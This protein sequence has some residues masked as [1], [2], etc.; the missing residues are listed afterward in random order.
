MN[1]I[2]TNSVKFKSNLLI[3]LFFGIIINGY[4][5][6]TTAENLL[7]KM[8]NEG[9]QNSRAMEM[10]SELT[11]VYGPRLNGSREYFAAANWISNEMKDIGIQN[12]HF[13]KYCPQCRG[14]SITSFNLEMTAP[15]YMHISGYP[16]VYTKSSNGKVSGE[17]VHVESYEDM[18]EVKNQFAGNL[19]GKVILLGKEPSRESLSEPL[20]SRFSEEE[21]TKMEEK[22]TAEVKQTPLP[23][24]IKSWETED[25]GEDEFLRFVEAEGGLA[26]LKTESMHLGI[27][28]PAGTYY[29]NM[30][31][32]KP[33][34]YFAIMPE[35]FGR[36]LRM[37][38]IGMVPLISLNLETEFYDESENSVNIIGQ[39]TGSDPKLKK[40]QIIIGAHFD[41]WH[42]STGATDNGANNV[43]LVE[44]LRILTQA[45][46]TPRRT[47]VIGLWGGEELAYLGSLAYA[48]DHFG[49]L[50]EEPNTE[51]KKVSV[52]LNLDS[53][54][55]AIRGIFLQENEFARPVFSKIFKPIKDLCDGTITI[56]NDL[57]T[58]HET[59][60]HYNIPA[61]QFIQD[62]LAYD[63][64]THHTN[65]DVLEYVPEKDIM[66]NAVI[67]A[68]IIY[69][70][71]EMNEKVP[72]KSN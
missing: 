56:E 72:R 26:V 3:F 66:K 49:S 25:F 28:H 20:T 60:D 34:P 27:L 44:A 63:T 35:H 33:L 58:D 30:N 61:F 39:I 5:Q 36:M 13:E 9:F 15:N 64:A 59:F 16:L 50:D 48:R 18:D 1:S 37:L 54:V 29:Y 42:S 17:L 71:A 51:S 22:L 53:G 4:S 67:L 57:S 32:L 23:E 45:G 10:L 7:A 68:W 6:Q 2:N 62:P 19:E 46:Y 21:L 70:L 31:H 14:W 55:G 11:D 69:S 47:I 41:S 43:V 24:L 38:N 52:Y 65:L 8:R 40:E 12:V